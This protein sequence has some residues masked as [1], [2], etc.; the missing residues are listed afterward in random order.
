MASPSHLPEMSVDVFPEPL[1]L[2]DLA[3]LAEAPDLS[4]FAEPPDLSWIQKD[5]DPL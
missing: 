3:W 2:L 4:G 5:L 1:E